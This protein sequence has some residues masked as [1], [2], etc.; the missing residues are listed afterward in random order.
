MFQTLNPLLLRLVGTQYHNVCGLA[1]IAVILRQRIQYM[2]AMLS[3]TDSS[4]LDMSILL[5]TFLKESVRTSLNFRSQPSCLQQCFHIHVCI[6]RLSGRLCYYVS[7]MGP[8]HDD[9]ETKQVH[10]P[11]KGT[12]YYTVHKP[13]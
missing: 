11:K 8:R 3:T 2:P 13:C 7:P 10:K 6:H 1:V 9:M 12:R 5:I 4:N